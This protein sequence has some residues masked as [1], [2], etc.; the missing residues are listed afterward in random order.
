MTRCTRP[1]RSAPAHRSGAQRLQYWLT[2]GRR[3]KE[4]EGHNSHADPPSQRAGRRRADIRPPRRR[5]TGRRCSDHVHHVGQLGHELD[6]GHFRLEFQLRV[7]LHQELSGHGQRVWLRVRD[8]FVRL[9]RTTDVRFGQRVNLGLLG[10]LD[11]R[12]LAP[13]PP[14]RNGRCGPDHPPGPRRPLSE[15]QQIY[16]VAPRASRAH[17]TS[18]PSA[19]SMCTA[20][21]SSSGSRRRQASIPK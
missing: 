9:G 20:T 15:S 18:S 7:R 8:A 11:R 16:A 10:L 4:T 2:R 13:T 19:S 3:S 5:C 14:Q 6:V 17:T 12:R 1:R 21:S